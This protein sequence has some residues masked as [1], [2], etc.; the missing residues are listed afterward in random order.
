MKAHLLK[1]EWINTDN[2]RGM[3]SKGH[4]DGS[5]FLTACEKY[6]GENLS[7]WKGIEWLWFRF[8]P[9]R[10][11]SSDRLGF[12]HEAKPYSRGAFPVTV[13]FKSK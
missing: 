11:D 3:M 7:H 5:E 1:I 6:T 12:Y 10:D 2:L 9:N 4:H 8:V 13:I